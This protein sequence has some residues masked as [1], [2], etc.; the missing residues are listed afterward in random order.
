MAQQTSA[1]KPHTTAKL[2]PSRGWLDSLS[3]Q[4]DINYS[5]SHENLVLWHFIKI[6]HFS[7]K[8]KE[9]SLFECIQCILT[10]FK[11]SVV[12]CKTNNDCAPETADALVTSTWSLVLKLNTH[13][14]LYNE[15]TNI[16]A[17]D[18]GSHEEDYD[19]SEGRDWSW[20]PPHNTWGKTCRWH[21][22]GERYCQ[23]PGF[24]D[25]LRSS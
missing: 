1:A 17:R 3:S 16:S 20:C 11:W 5:A 12:P 15:F 6:L 22:S 9:Q 4:L 2:L 14:L 23:W 24:P 18:T 21:W 10:L 7:L 19:V 13:C 8:K 25:S